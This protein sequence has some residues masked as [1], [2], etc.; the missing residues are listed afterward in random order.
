VPYPLKPVWIELEP[1][2]VQ[3]LLAIALDGKAEEALSFVR[4]DLLQRVEKA[5][6]RR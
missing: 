4:G 6:E 5:L 3:R 2:Q 1:E